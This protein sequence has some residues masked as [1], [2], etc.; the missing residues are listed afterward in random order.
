LD[1]RAP[2]RI[3]ASCFALSAFAIA[4]ISGLAAGRSTSAILTTAILALLACYI[5][6]LLIATVANVAVTERINTY[7]DSNPV[8]DSS[9]K[10]Q[11]AQQP[12]RPKPEQSEPQQTIDHSEQA[13]QAA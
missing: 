1:S 4:L 6:G 12:A 5:L 13:T 2:A 11:A 10:P 9:R 8:P 3:I 7:K